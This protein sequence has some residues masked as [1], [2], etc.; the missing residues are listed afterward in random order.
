MSRSGSVVVTE[1]RQLGSTRAGR[2]ARSGRGG[3]SS[4]TGTVAGGAV[5]DLTWCLAHRLLAHT[6]LIGLAGVVFFLLASFPF[7]ANLLELC[8]DN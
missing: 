6:I 5:A 4:T 1:R 8:R 7:L 2:V 3:S